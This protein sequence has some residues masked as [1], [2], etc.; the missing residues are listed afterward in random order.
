MVVLVMASIV[1]YS[2][3]RLLHGLSSGASRAGPSD[4]VAL[5]V[6]RLRPAPL[7]LRRPALPEQLGVG[8]CAV[9]ASAASAA[10]PEEF[11]D[12]RQLALGEAVANAVAV[13]GAPADCCHQEL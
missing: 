4:D 3:R 1:R 8:R 7:D 6:A 5:T 12:D 2:A 13:L 10:L 11:T 9:S